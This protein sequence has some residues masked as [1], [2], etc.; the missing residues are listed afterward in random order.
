[1][2]L[3]R[4]GIMA[5]LCSASHGEVVLPQNCLYTELELEGKNITPA[6]SDIAFKKLLS[7]A[8]TIWKLGDGKN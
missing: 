6:V 5:L 4:R 3:K 1:M 7:A 8:P 2:Q